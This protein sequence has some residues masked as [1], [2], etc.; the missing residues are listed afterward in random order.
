MIAFSGVCASR[1]VLVAKYARPVGKDILDDRPLVAAL[2]C[3]LFLP[4]SLI[5]AVSI[6][7]GTNRCTPVALSSGTERRE[8]ARLKGL[9]T[10]TARTAV[11]RSEILLFMPSSFFSAAHACSYERMPQPVTGT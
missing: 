6:S 8:L 10:R 2:G 3:T 9:G 7:L 5:Q 11:R 4:N 1:S